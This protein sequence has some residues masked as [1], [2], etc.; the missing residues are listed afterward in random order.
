MFSVPNDIV[1]TEQTCHRLRN[2]FSAVESTTVFQ[3]FGSKKWSVDCAELASH[4]DIQMSYVESGEQ[5]Q[6]DWA[7]ELNPGDTALSSFP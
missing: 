1:V 2:L 5:R 7:T 6:Q 3:S 4:S